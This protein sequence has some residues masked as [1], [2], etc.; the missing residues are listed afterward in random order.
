MGGKL[1]KWSKT[2]L[3]TMTPR[4]IVSSFLQ[5]PKV[6]TNL[7][8]M[9][10]DQT[11]MSEENRKYKPIIRTSR[12]EPARMYSGFSFNHFPLRSLGSHLDPRSFKTI[13][14]SLKQLKII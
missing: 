10:Y 14:S 13:P 12:S 8:Q 4:S 2:D 5:V 1:I 6:Q 3:P 7:K 11:S 9:Y